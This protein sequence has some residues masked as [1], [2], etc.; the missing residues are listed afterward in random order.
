MRNEEPEIRRC[1][2]SIAA[3]DYPADLL[4]VL[5]Y[6]GLSTDGSFAAAREV[7]GHRP[8]WAVLSNPPPH[9]GSGLE[10]GHTSRV[11]RDRRHRERSLGARRRVRPKC[12]SGSDRDRRRHGGRPCEGRGGRC[13]RCRDRHRHEQPVWRRGCAP[14]L[15]HGTGL[16]RHR[17]H[18]CRSAATWLEYPFDETFVRN[19][20]DEL[21]YRL[22]D[23]GGRILCDP[24]IKSTY[25]SRSTFRD[26]RQ[27]RHTATGRSGSSRRTPV[28]RDVVT[29]HRWRL[30]AP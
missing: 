12:G 13:D 1:L 22:L 10:R 21:S 19:Q 23:G 9:S 17:F 24:A 27:Y 3:Q 20:D 14:P 11:R 16:R 2:T 25:R 26:L 4:E 30:L 6:D 7:A 29:W 28:R 5:V 8:D 15:R 18:G